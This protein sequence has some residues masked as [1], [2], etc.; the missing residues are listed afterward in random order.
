MRRWLLISVVLVACKVK[1]APPITAT[2]SDAF[3]RGA[4]GADYFSTGDGYAVEHGAMSAH[5]AHNHPLWLR[6]KLP[7]D[8]RIELDCWSTEPRGDIK[9]EL[10]GDGRSY[11]PDGGRYMATGYEIIQGGWFNSKSIIARMDEHAPD[12]KA[13]TEP[14]VVANQHY[15]WKLERQGHVLRW[16]VDDMTSPFLQLDDVH[17]LEGGGHEYFAFNNWETDT[18]FDN[19]V[20]T[21]L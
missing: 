7:H 1:E 15:H 18:W 19:L 14:K 20:I 13:R 17:P 2:W 4:P 12:V 8:V 3:E 16:Y 5:G 21:P 9:V 10:F 11:D 6:R